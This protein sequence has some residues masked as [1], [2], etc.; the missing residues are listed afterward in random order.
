MQPVIN[1]GRG[2]HFMSADV[3]KGKQNNEIP[4]VTRLLQAYSAIAGTSACVSK[5]YAHF[6]IFS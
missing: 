4:V 2:V 3:L 1:G 6:I 5:E